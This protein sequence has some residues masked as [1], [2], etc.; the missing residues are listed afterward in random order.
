MYATEIRHVKKTGRIC[1]QLF[2]AEM[3]EIGD[4]RYILA[5]AQDITSH[6][7]MEAEL[8][9]ARNLESIGTLAGGIA[10]DFNNLLMAVTGYISLAKILFPSDSQ[11]FGFLADA[12][13][14][15]LAGKGTDSEIDHLLQRRCL[16]QKCRGPC[17]RHLAWVTYGPCRIECAM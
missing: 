16:Y 2:S 13:R 3:M 6:K 8:T 4:A 11:G 14:I 10:H 9:K 1:T 5:A 12:E 17:A 7:Q 15:S